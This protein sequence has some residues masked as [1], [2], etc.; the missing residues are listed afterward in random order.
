MR[1]VRE[2]AVKASSGAIPI[3]KSKELASFVYHECTRSNCWSGCKRTLLCKAAMTSRFTNLWTRLQR[4]FVAKEINALKLKEILINLLDS[5]WIQL[6]DVIHTLHA[7]KPM[8]MDS[9]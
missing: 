6:Y 1:M 7:T 3:T 4:V 9:M 8:T 5:V 2:K